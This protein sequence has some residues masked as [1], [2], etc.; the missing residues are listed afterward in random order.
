MSQRL[1]IEEKYE[2]RFLFKQ[3]HSIHEI[4]RKMKINR[5]TV[6]KWM[7]KDPSPTFAI[8]SESRGRKRK[9][10]TQHLKAI[11]RI[12]LTNPFTGSQ[13]LTM[14]VKKMT[15]LDISSRTL[16]RYASD[17]DLKWGRFR[18]V[19]F[20]T[21]VHKEKRY[22]WALKHV[23]TDWNNW[24]FSDEKIFRAGAAPVGVRYRRG[25]QPFYPTKRWS[26]QVFI[27]FA[28]HLQQSFK[29]QVVES[30][31]NNVTYRVILEK[32]LVPDYQKP[33]I[34]QQD[35]ARP[36]IAKAVKSWM[37]EKNIDICQDWPANSPD[38]NPIENLWSTIDFEVRK[39]CP[40]TKERLRK[41]VLS[42][43]R[44]I[45]KNDITSLIKSMPRRI[46]EVIKNKGG[47]IKY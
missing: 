30:T 44:N 41:I 24:V 17:F 20:L 31:L 14:K 34:F 22:A 39:R 11:K 16:R 33:M 27:W 23:N 36:H 7:N 4:S 19:P 8:F 15:G 6:R 43:I 47:N 12:L 46:E 1:S 29:A 3:G 5:N 38:L 13:H 9:A 45:R 26:G 21:D 32:G 10:S 40:R 37:G 18:K 2:I 42:V 28:I 35:N 25:H